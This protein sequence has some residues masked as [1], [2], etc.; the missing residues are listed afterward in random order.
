MGLTRHKIKQ[1]QKRRNYT[2]IQR[3][4][5]KSNLRFQYTRDP[6][7]ISWVTSVSQYG[8]EL[9]RMISNIPYS[10]YRFEGECDIF[11]PK[12]N[13]ENTE[14]KLSAVEN[15]S[16]SIHRYEGIAVAQ[17]P[18]Y[19]IFGGTA[20]EIY[21]MAYPQVANLYATT[22]PTGDIDIRLYT[23]IFKSQDKQAEGYGTI[24]MYTEK[25][26]YNPVSDNYTRWIMEHIR[27]ILEILSIQYAKKLQKG[28]FIPASIADT[29][30]SSISDE[31]IQVGPFI[32]CRLYRDN[33]IKIQAIAKIQEPDG[34]EYADH[35][36]EFVMIIMDKGSIDKPYKSEYFT[37]N[38]IIVDSPMNLL[39][40]QI[41]GLNDRQELQPEVF[42]KL[43]NHYGRLM[44]ITKLIR[45]M[46]D[47]K[48][49]PSP[50]TNEFTTF[51]NMLKSSA[52]DRA[53]VC[54][55]PRGCSAYAILEPLLPF[56]LPYFPLTKKAR[57]IRHP[58]A[59]KG[60]GNLENI[61]TNLFQ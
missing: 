19:Q 54:A 12:K 30:E 33:M 37:I 4:G 43:I 25:N 27:N 14:F 9:I 22:D 32:I 34:T 41:K 56:F 5:N 2:R 13:T 51:I 55:P 29:Y 3:G 49:I 17:D 57:T 18:A 48:L 35:F 11:I 6:I 59:V 61:Q 15:I 20:C 28:G 50:T 26:G 36:M 60:A 40:G 44:Y 52:F 10:E 21:N 23:P 38:N 31:H 16:G 53:D 42:Y 8:S 47:N 7:R 39:K 46:A 24:V 45:W 58:E 1:K